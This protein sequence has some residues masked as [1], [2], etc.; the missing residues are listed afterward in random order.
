MWAFYCLL[1]LGCR[2][3]LHSY[4]RGCCCLV[5]P[6]LVLTFACTIVGACFPLSAFFPLGLLLS[7]AITDGSEFHSW[8][9]V[10]GY[11]KGRLCHLG[12]LCPVLA[13]SCWLCSRLALSLSDLQVLGYLPGWLN[14]LLAVVYVSFVICM[15]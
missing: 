1:S 11:F 13:S 8:L 5:F 6:R 12:V 10:G 9:A 15:G 3:L 4:L 2:C 14:N 7:L